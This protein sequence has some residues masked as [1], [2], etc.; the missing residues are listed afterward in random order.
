MA[1]VRTTRARPR[2]ERGAVGGPVPT[3][4]ERSDGGP[5]GPKDVPPGHHA[6]QKDEEEEDHNNN[7]D[8][9]DG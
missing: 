1:P 7:D 5:N 6:V 9:D 4:K 8:N 3:W 2:F